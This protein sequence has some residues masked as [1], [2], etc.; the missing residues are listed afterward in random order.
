[1]LQPPTG[2][3][4][5]LSGFEEYA[6]SDRIGIPDPAS[7]GQGGRSRTERWPYE[8]FGPKD[9]VVGIEI[10]GV[11]RAYPR[12]VVERAGGVLTDTLAGAAVAVVATEEGLDVYRA[13]GVRIERGPDGIRADG[14]SFDPATGWTGDGRTLERVPARRPF[15]FTWRDDTAI[16]SIGNSVGCRCRTLTVV[17]ACY[18]LNGV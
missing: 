8:S 4:P 18:R 3:R 5:D 6:T 9:R 12:P 10:D 16:P 1:V 11:V 2:E 13:D 14:I 7:A 15:A 17:L